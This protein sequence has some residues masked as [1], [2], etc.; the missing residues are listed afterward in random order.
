MNRLAALV[1]ILVLGGCATR[2]PHPEAFAFGIIGDTP[3]DEHETVPFLYAIEA[4]NADALAFSVHLGDMKAGGDSPCTDALYAERKR[5]FDRYRHPFLFIPGDNE[6]VD[7]RRASNGAMDPLERLAKLRSVFYEPTIPP[8]WRA[9]DMQRHPEYPEVARW[10]RGGVVFVTLNVQ[11]SNDN[12]GFDRASDREQERRS[13]VNLAWLA[14]AVQ[15]AVDT[16][17]R[18]LAVI[19]Q[20]DPFLESRGKVFD[21]LLKALVDS[22]ET[23]HRPMLFIHG[24]T[25]WQRVDKPFTDAGGRTVANLTRLETYG[26]PWVGWVKVFVDPDDPRLFRFEARPQ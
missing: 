16:H 11:G 17:A 6:W 20:A 23:L 19:I 10:T 2:P 21:P 24:D 26:S 5:H 1:I 3:Y 7:C 14:E 9:L 8:A 13:A 12:V 22:A 25:H 18:G 15:L 4:M